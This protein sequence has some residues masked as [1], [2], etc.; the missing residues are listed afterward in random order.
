MYYV[1]KEKI[2]STKELGKFLKELIKKNNTDFEL[3]MAI[4]KS[5]GHLFKDPKNLD[6]LIHRTLDEKYKI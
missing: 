6:R 4:E 3:S 1:K 2:L 5:I